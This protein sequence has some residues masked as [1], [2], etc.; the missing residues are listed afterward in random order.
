MKRLLIVL[1]VLV[2]FGIACGESTIVPN[3]SSGATTTHTITYQVVGTARSA[4]ITYE[5]MQGGTEQGDYKLPIKKE[6]TY[7]GS[8]PAGQFLYISAQNDSE[9]G[10][11]T[12]Q[13]LVDGTV[14]KT[15]TSSGAYVICT[16]S[17]M[18]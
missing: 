1:A 16:A 15:S 3:N 2:M 9:S 11:V 5:N 17:G 6:W 14:W 13:I 12:C 10:T 4:S 8:V 18:T 7:T